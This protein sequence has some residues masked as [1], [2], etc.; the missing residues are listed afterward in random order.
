M[1]ARQ[2]RLCRSIEEVCPMLA[3]LVGREEDCKNNS[4]RR[5]A[6]KKGGRTVWSSSCSAC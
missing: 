1:V 5:A 6:R 4:A 2:Q 3:L